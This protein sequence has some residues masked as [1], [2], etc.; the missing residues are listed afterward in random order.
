LNEEAA[1]E[2]QQPKGGDLF[3][4]VRQYQVGDQSSPQQTLC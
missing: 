1:R 2:F 3:C 4:V